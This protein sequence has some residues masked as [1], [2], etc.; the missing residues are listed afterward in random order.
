MSC[1]SLVRLH[2]GNDRRVASL[3]S[4]VPLVWRVPCVEG[5]KVRF[6]KRIVDVAA[7]LARLRAASV[8]VLTQRAPRR[9]GT[10]ELRVVRSSD[11]ADFEAVSEQRG[12][13]AIPGRRT[14]ASTVAGRERPF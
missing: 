4:G 9:L 1:A 7:Q 8:N 13:E 2:E 14:R 5:T 6:K 3:S 12:G 11:E 10:S